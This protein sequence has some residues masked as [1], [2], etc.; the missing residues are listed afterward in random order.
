M[1]VSW[2]TRPVS[3]RGRVQAAGWRV[4]HRLAVNALVT[5]GPTPPELV[6]TPLEV[7]SAPP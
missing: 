1:T 2:P 3:W 6:N 4:G 7:A 5:V